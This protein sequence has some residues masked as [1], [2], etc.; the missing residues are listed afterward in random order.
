MS[1]GLLYLVQDTQLIGGPTHG[2]PSGGF[3]IREDT[4]FVGVS[5]GA[6]P[7]GGFAIREDTQFVAGPAAAEGA[8]GF[9]IR[10]VRVVY[11][12]GHVCMEMSPMHASL[13]KWKLCILARVRCIVPAHTIALLAFLQDTQLIGGPSAKQPAGGFAIREDTQFVGPAPVAAGVGFSIREVGV[14]Q[15]QMN[16]TAGDLTAAF[17]G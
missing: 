17:P 11:T 12:A 9:S 7:A 6:Q 10:E 1:R 2:Q 5:I 3:S 14:D 15:M 4:Q 16:P 8:D 13:R